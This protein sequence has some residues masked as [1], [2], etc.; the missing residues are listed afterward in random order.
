[1]VEAAALKTEPLFTVIISGWRPHF[2]PRALEA[3]MGQ[4]YKN[5][6][7]LLFDNYP[8]Q[9]NSEIGAAVTNIIH[10]FAARDSRI[11]V[12]RLPRKPFTIERPTL[13]Y[14]LMCGLGLEKALGE[15][16]I[17]QNDDDYFSNDYIEKMVR[18]F[19]E[20]PACISAAGL[21]VA[22]NEQGEKVD[23]TRDSNFRPRH[24]PGHEM[25]L[26]LI[27]G[28]DM[29]NSPG[30]TIF[31]YKRKPY[32]ELGGQHAASDFRHLFG[33]IPFGNTGFDDT[34]KFYW[35]RHEGQFNKS[36]SA[37]GWVSARENLLFL[38]EWKIKDRWERFG[39]ENAFEVVGWIREHVYCYS[40]SWFVINL[41]K[42]R[43]R[44]CLRLASPVWTSPRF[45]A[46]IPGA[47]WRYSGL[48]GLPYRTARFIYRKF[49]IKKVLRKVQKGISQ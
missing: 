17:I 26:D 49:G 6:E 41:Y 38:D 12:I 35:V 37:Q 47:L 36:L 40:A 18:L 25:A 22:I 23:G 2:L 13:N 39:K 14:D 9:D 10:E 16:F 21:P 15:Y 43:L 20:D 5:L 3:L 34:A 45:Y 19:K 29:Y 7:I 48:P 32:M 1:M 44:A 8:A 4:T 46:A 24:M 30:A 28:G 27:R 11:K 42:L 31:A 33:I